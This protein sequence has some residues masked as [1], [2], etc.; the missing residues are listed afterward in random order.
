MP[1]V[2]L[3]SD[4]THSM[5]AALRTE[6]GLHEVSLYVNHG[7]RTEREAEMDLQVFY[8]RLRTGDKLPTT[9]QPSIGDFLAV[10]EPLL[11]AGQDVVSVHISGQISGTVETARQAAEDATSRFP[12]RRIEVVDSRTVAG[13]LAMVLLA[14]ASS[15]AAGEDLDTIV[16]RTEAAAGPDGNQIWFAVDTL[17]FLRKG[18]RIG[19]ASAWIGGALKIKPILTVDGEVKPVERVRTS[20]RAFQRLVTAMDELTT[21][22]KTAWCIQHIQAHAEAERLAVVGRE[23]FGSEPLMISE[24]GAVVGTYA[25]PGLLGVGGLP[26]ALVGR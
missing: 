11:E 2:T 19:T 17:E 10:Y 5:P 22:G 23:H 20:G 12:D 3:V 6:L 1:P 13:G 21:L 9:S 14:S 26:P 8:D 18:G 15:I 7:T 16:A 24:I 4:S 25:G